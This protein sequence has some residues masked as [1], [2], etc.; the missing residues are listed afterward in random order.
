MLVIAIIANLFFFLLGLINLRY[1]RLK[2]GRRCF[3]S[4]KLRFFVLRIFSR[5]GFSLFRLRS[6]F[7]EEVLIGI[8]DIYIKSKSRLSLNIFCFF[9]Q[10]FKAVRLV[11]KLFY[12]DL[13]T[14]L[15][16][17]LKVSNYCWLIWGPN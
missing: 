10:F 6:T 12:F 4:L 7:L 13:N 3:M 17:F 11:F 14:R 15:Q 16:V 5:P 9:N 8:L 1:L 2:N